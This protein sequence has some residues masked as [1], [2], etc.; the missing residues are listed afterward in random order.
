MLHISTWIWGTKYSQDYVDR[1]AAGV[2]RAVKQEH[3]FRIFHPE[4]PDLPLTR[5]PGCLCRLRMFDPAWQR[6]QG[7]QPGD[8]LVTMDLDSVITGPLDPLFD[9]PEPFVIL[10]GANSLNPC[11]F[12]G[13]LQML[14]GDQH[15]Q[16][17]WDFSMTAVQSIPFF[18]Y[19]DDQAW[20]A[21]K[22]P[23]AAVWKVGRPSG[24]YAFKKPGW[25]HR[26]DD[27]L[28]DGARLVVFPGWRDPA[29][30]MKLSWVQKYWRVG[31]VN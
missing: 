13:S 4:P 5:I 15:P 9:R 3:R 2:A 23:G 25:D 10:G 12:N 16:I 14:R 11:P 17:W 26:N 24:V 31:D 6:R 20:I 7:I 27:R 29:Q 22:L 28:P 8:R 18:E 21:A 19:P 30:F 1:L